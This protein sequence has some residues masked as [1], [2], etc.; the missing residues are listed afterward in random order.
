M[1]GVRGIV[2]EAFGV[3]NMPWTK[4][5]G[6]IPGCGHNLKARNADL[7]DVTVRE[8]K[9]TSELYRTGSLALELGAESGL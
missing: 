8:W 1:R 2:L 5:T 7:H 6:W 9:I 3:G 4:A